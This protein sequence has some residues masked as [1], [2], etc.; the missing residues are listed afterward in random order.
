MSRRVDAVRHG[1]CSVDARDCFRR[2]ACRNRRACRCRTLRSAPCSPTAL[3]RW[4]IQFCQA[5]R[6]R[7]DLRLHGLRAGEAEVRLHAG[8]RVGREAC[9]LLEATRT[10][11]SQSMSSGAKVTRPSSRPPRAS[12][13]SPMRAC[14]AADAAG[15]AEETRLQPGQ[16]VAHRIAGRNSPSRQGQ[17]A[18][19]PVS[20]SNTRSACRSGPRPGESRPACRR[21]RA[22]LDQ[23][24]QAA[25]GDVQ[26]LERAL[27]VMH[28]LIGQPVSGLLEQELR[29]TPRPRGVARGLAASRCRARVSLMRRSQDRVVEFARE[30]QRP[31]I[32]ALRVR[33]PRRSA[34]GASSAPSTRD[35]ARARRRGRSRPRQRG[36][37]DAVVVECRAPAASA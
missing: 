2:G 10:S 35:R 17:P 26:P 3:G 36:Y 5:V 21:S 31:E 27:Q 7:E 12:S 1:V 25:R 8:Q 37:R 22:R 20:P 34:G 18:R 9:A 6:R 24:D 16:A 28:D 13:A 30:A 29:R 14:A 23:R 33:W 11:S 15:F 4:K 19:R 32:G